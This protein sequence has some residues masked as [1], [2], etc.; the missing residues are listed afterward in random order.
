MN[1]C[2]FEEKFGTEYPKGWGS[3]EFDFIGRALIFATRAHEG[4]TR[5][6]TDIPYIGHPIEAA[7]VAMGVFAGKEA[8]NLGISDE[9]EVI[10]AALL[11]D[12]VEDTEY[13]I[14]DIEREFGDKVA[15]L[16]GYESEDKMRTLSAA[17]SWKMRKV[18]FLEHLATAPI[19][20]KII[21]L[22]DKLSNMRQSAK[23]F[24][25]QGDDM[26]LV[27]NQKDKKEQEWYYRSIYENISELKE[28]EAYKEYVALCDKVFGAL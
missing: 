8:A 6:G 9:V 13:T 11:H 24:E 5:K 23:T 4:A 25:E 22:G 12:V 2:E 26:W 17:D 14:E 10:V 15:K 21:C 3:E 7:V 18:A 19:Q 20:A 27:F 28:T 16:V 1:K